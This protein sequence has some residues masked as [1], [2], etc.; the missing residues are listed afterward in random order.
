MTLV[1]DES[2]FRDAYEEHQDRLSSHRALPDPGCLE[3][4]SNYG[5]LLFAPGADLF[6]L[7]IPRKEWPAM[8]RAGQGSWLHDMVKDVLPPHDQG[9]TNYCWAHAPTRAHEVNNLWEG[10]APFELSAESV[11][12]PITGG[13]NRGGRIEDAVQQIV[14]HGQCIQAMWP[15]NSRDIK[16]P[17]PEWKDNRRHFRFL[18]HADVNGFDMQMTF[19][20]LRIPVAIGLRWWGHAICQLD[21]ILFDDGTFGIGCDNS[22]GKSYGDNGYFILTEKRGTADLGAIA[23]LS[24]TFLANFP[25][26]G[27]RAAQAT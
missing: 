7:P 4:L 25:P 12:V 11:A 14:N 16:S 21:P 19:A 17:N 13:A 15:K 5:H 27:P 3:R 2:N 23:P 1:I 18:T 6:I 10:E 24:S 26:D 8:I 9:Q 20:L 22:W